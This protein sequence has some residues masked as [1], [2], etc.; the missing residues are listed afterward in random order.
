MPKRTDIKKIMVIGAGPTVIGQ[1]AEYDWAGAQACAA[2]REDG[3]EVV[4]IN[5]NPATVTTDADVADRIYIEPLTLEYVARVLRH[6][7][8]DAVIPALGGRTALG[9]ALALHR[10]GILRECRTALIGTDADA[11]EKTMDRERFKKFC[12]GLGEPVLPSA[13]VRTAEEGAEAA[14]R[15]GYPVMLRPAF[16]RGETDGSFACDEADLRRIIKN[17]LSAS[18]AG[19]VLM[20]KSIRGWKEIALEV[21][22][23]GSDAVISVCALENVDPVGIHAG[24]SIVVAPCQSLSE[25]N[26]ALLRGHAAK[27]VRALGITGVCGVRFALS[28]VSS[29]YYLLGVRP[30]VS[31][32]SALAA[33]ATGYPVARVMAKAAV[34]LKLDEVMLGD[35]S[36]RFD[37]VLDC[38]AVRM[39]RFP[40]DKFPDASNRLGTQMKATGETMAIGKTLGE[41]LLKAVRSL[42]TGVCHLYLPKFDGMDKSELLDYVREG[43]E[44]RIHAL[45]QLFRLGAGIDEAA[46]S[47]MIAPVFLKAVETVVA[48]EAPVAAKPFDLSAL[49]QAK[50]AGFSDS[51]IAKLWNA[52]ERAVCDFRLE[53]RILPEYVMADTCAKDD[54]SYIPCFYSSYSG[55]GR[56]G[57][58]G[59]KKIIVLGSGPNRIGQG[60]EFDYAT[61][62]AAHAVK[63]LGYEAIII[64]DNPAAVSTDLSVGDKLYL[65][66]LTA[67]S[68]TDIAERERP[69]GVIAAMGGRTAIALAPVLE[70]RGL[71]LIGTGVTAITLS[72]D[73]DSFEKLLLSLGIP[74][75]PCRAVT[76]ADSGAAAAAKAGY[77]VLARL[78]SAP[79]GRAIV[80]NEAALRTFLGTADIGE[81]APAFVDKYLAGRE[82]EVDA[83]C[84]GA[85]VFIPGIMEHVERTGI[86]SGDSI[87]IYPTF[88]VSERAKGK[89]LEYTR[90]L[91]LALGGVGLLNVQFIVDKN[92]RVYVIE[93]SAGASRTVPFLSKATGWPISDIAVFAML[94]KG[95]REQGIFTLYPEEKKKTY[96]KV[97][98]F[99]FSKLQGMDA[100][101]S[102]EM[103]STGEAMGCDGQLTRAL[104]KALQAS[105]LHVQNYG[106]VFATI[107]DTDKDE[108]LPLIRRFYDLGF[109]IE[110]TSGTAA[111]LKENGIRTHVCAKLSEGSGEILDSIRSGHV[112]Y[113]INTRDPDSPSGET[114]GMRIRRCATENNVAIFT[115]LDTVR[116]LLD[117]LEEMTICVE[118]LG[119]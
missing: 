35:R 42:D 63:K 8:P 88:S 36:A 6:E 69:L 83:V 30:G 93:A 44:D 73:R 108:A 103:K 79:G 47:T 50:K 54:W 31:R 12:G 113:V 1:S 20:E 109:N 26:L 16:T 5:A 75:P 118:P 40:F 27:I 43:T 22:R 86:H 87:C 49:L 76:D 15:L 9:L 84:D 99:S 106:T 67:E 85:D 65:E 21:L 96:V 82:I 66:P 90:K 70:A 52:P 117:V 115:S 97:P 48:A 46:V 23:D 111:F 98:V 55:A 100:Y 19:Q 114:D 107:A 62:H 24:D 41:A 28:P 77:P 32:A 60:A 14:N 18:P 58:S 34:G 119:S 2:L 74:Q 101:L 91:G 71:K 78:S 61:V 92:D 104:Y 80:G 95:L 59:R 81:D 33:K 29:D 45:A 38:I 37:P 7:R 13:V 116:V 11:I 72:E 57:V 68:V 10:K 89:I 112:T 110:A 51:Y 25:E 94:G 39:P 105:G 4:L 3:Y 53:N 64:N 17:V 102:P 56:H